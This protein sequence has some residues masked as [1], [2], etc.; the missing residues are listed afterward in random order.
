[1][2]APGMAAT[3]TFEAQPGTSENTPGLDSFKHV[4]GTRGRI[5]AITAQ[6]RRNGILIK[7]DG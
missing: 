2:T 1:M 6:Q 3:N 7:A 4:L 5:A